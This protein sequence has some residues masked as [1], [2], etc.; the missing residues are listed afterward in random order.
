MTTSV[1]KEDKTMLS[2]KLTNWPWAGQL[3]GLGKN[4]SCMNEAGKLR[5]QRLMMD[6]YGF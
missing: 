6:M 4:L 5:S 2:T 3:R 1:F